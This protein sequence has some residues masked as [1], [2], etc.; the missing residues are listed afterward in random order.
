MREYLKFYIDGQWATPASAERIPVTEAA[1]EEPLGSVP[2][3]TERDIDALLEGL[4]EHAV[5]DRR[6]VHERVVVDEVLEAPLP[7]DA[8]CRCEV[9]GKP[10]A[11]R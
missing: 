5:V 7:L 6:E 11:L 4:A 1:T 10:A 9:A 3:A 2:A 8:R